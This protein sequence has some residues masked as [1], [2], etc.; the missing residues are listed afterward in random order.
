MAMNTIL[1]VK[2]NNYVPNP[3]FVRLLLRSFFEPCIK[4]KFTCANRVFVFHGDKSLILCS[5]FEQ[6]DKYRACAIFQNQI[7]VKFNSMIYLRD[8][9]T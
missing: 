6:S 5:F 8:E 4:I 9:I 3:M 7:V 1:N 2:I